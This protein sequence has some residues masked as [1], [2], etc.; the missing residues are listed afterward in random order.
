MS[1][2]LT[3]SLSL[4]LLGTAVLMTATRL[5]YASGNSPQTNS[6]VQE[7]WNKFRAA[8]IKGDKASVTALTRFPVE[9][10]YGMASVKNRTQLISRYRKVFKGQ[11]D[12]AKCFRTA[13][14]QSDPDNAKLFSVACKNAAG[15]E[16]IIYSFARTANGWKFVGLDNL[17]E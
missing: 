2:V 3:W 17:N 5:S 13:K 6:S 8:V 15:H 7:F 4:V 11:T 16:V 9:M 12:A 14:P 10:P 1:K